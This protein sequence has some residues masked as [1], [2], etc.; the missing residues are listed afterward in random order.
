MAEAGQTPEKAAP[1]AHQGDHD[2]IAMLSL[3]AD[4]TANQHNPEVIIDRDQAVEATKVQFAQQAVSVVDIDERGVGGG[5][6]G[7]TLVGQKD[8]SVKS[9]PLRTA[10]GPGIDDLTAKHEAAQAAGEKA[11]EQAVDKLIKG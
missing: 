3:N 5:G 2:R 10:A 8:G 11:A 6:S 4:G 9:E 7:V 1:L